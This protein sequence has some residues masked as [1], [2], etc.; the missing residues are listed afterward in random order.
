MGIVEKMAE[1]DV[2]SGTKGGLNQNT[3]TRCASCGHLDRFM[4]AAVP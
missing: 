1:K 4:F 2:I 3:G